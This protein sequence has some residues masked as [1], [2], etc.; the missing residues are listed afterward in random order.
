M[1][2]NTRVGEMVISAM[3]NG[4]GRDYLLRPSFYAMSQLG[5]PDQIERT[6]DK[7]KMAMRVITYGKSYCLTD[8]VSHDQLAHCIN[9]I[10]ACSI[11]DD[12][13]DELLGWFQ[14]SAKQDRLLYRAGALDVKEIIIIANHLMKWGMIGQPDPMRL[15]MPR[16]KGEQ[17]KQFD[18]V[19][20]VGYA[21]QALHLSK[22]DAWDLTMFEFQRAIEKAFP[23]DES[24][25]PV[26]TDEAEAAVAQAKAAQQR[27]KEMN[28]QPRNGK[29]A[30]V[31]KLIR[32]E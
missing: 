23:I 21:I 20:Y 26:S 17:P 27:R 24:K 18:P 19:E 1:R 22:S 16:K 12:L 5:E 6:Y 30:E 10:E 29:I 14:L 25:I 13:P 15:R 32:R 28:I 7:C 8:T 3:V 11:N 4:E 9:V 2:C 31:S